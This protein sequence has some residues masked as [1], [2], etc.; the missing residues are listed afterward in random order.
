MKIAHRCPQTPCGSTCESKRTVLQYLEH[1]G[2][3]ISFMS[4]AFR[5][6]TLLTSDRGSWMAGVG[7][8]SVSFNQEGQVVFVR[9]AEQTSFMEVAVKIVCWECLV[10]MFPIIYGITVIQ[11]QAACLSTPLFFLP[12]WLNS[13]W[14]LLRFSW[15]AFLGFLWCYAKSRVLH[16]LPFERCKTAAT[17][18]TEYIGLAVAAGKCWKHNGS[19][20]AIF[21]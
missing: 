4:V 3:F 20:H 7:H 10:P 11:A 8:P 14:A 1:P 19:S 18:T 17:T 12:S 21:R 16:S 2:T 13:I 9:E 15:L 5:G 6:A